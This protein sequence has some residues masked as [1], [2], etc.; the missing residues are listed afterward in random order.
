LIKIGKWGEEMEL[1]HT[2]TQLALNNQKRIRGEK[3]T[4][5]RGKKIKITFII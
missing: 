1:T 4:N 5:K 2:N 3:F